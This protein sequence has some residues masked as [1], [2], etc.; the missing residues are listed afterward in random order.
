MM[1][2]VSVVCDGCTCCCCVKCCQCKQ[3]MIDG[4]GGRMAM[5]RCCQK[6]SEMMYCHGRIAAEVVASWSRLIIIF[7]VMREVRE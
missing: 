6:C 1:E 7:G 5:I 3:Q 2:F 4:Q